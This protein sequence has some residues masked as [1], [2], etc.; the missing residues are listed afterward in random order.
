MPPWRDLDCWQEA[1]WAVDH[2][3]DFHA[4]GL[5]GASAIAAEILAAIQALSPIMDQL[6]R[7]TC[8]ECTACCCRVATVWYDFRDLLYLR[9]VR[10]APVSGQVRKTMDGCSL[11][12]SNGCRLPREVRPFICT[13]YLCP[14]QKLL[15]SGQDNSL[16]STMI[17]GIERIRRL[18]TR[19]E[20]TF[21]TVVSDRG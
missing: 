18:R 15:V 10:L 2:A 19:L 16:Y 6:C 11:L 20:T 12:G 17:P 13:W 14:P 4:G 1:C 7:A 8:P 21:L 9:L 3:L 5:A